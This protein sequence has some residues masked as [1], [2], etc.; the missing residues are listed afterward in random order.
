MITAATPAAGAGRRG[1]GTTTYVAFQGGEAPSP[2]PPDANAA[3]EGAPRQRQPLLDSLARLLAQ[4][5]VWAAGAIRAAA[6]GGCG[7]AP[8]LSCR[9]AGA[10]TSLSIVLRPALCVCA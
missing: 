1:R 5:A 10:S 7:A 4:R 3:G 8:P 9:P 6:E 2:A